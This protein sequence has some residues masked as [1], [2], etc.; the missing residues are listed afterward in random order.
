MCIAFILT[1]KILK[2]LLLKFGNLLRW[3]CLP[4]LTYWPNFFGFTMLRPK[5][6]FSYIK[7][8]KTKLVS[9]FQPKL[10]RV[11]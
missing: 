9:K 11:L 2:F 6:N 5:N 8:R 1:P 4:L 7:K 10:L 3:P